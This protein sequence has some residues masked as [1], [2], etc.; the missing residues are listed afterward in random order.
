MCV[1]NKSY[2]GQISATSEQCSSFVTGN[3]N[4]P[5][6]RHLVEGGSTTSLLCTQEMHC[7]MVGDEQ[8]CWAMIQMD[9]IQMDD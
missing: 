1:V 9:L 4:P 7:S 5:R 3:V 2:K 6:Q 8:E